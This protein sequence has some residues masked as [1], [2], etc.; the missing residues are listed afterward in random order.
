MHAWKQFQTIRNAHLFNYF[1][2]I[3]YSIIQFLWKSCCLDV[4]RRKFDKII[5][6]IIHFFAMIVN[7]LSHCRSDFF[8]IFLIEFQQFLHSID[9]V[10]N[11]F[12]FNSFTNWI[13]I[14]NI[15]TEAHS[16][17]KVFIHVKEKHWG[18]R[19]YV[20]VVIELR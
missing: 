15:R 4:F 13:I 14:R 16:W 20:V 8:H 6:L 7:L 3:K 12:C 11:F 9:D 18:E 1:E 17:M 2:W 5:D 10:I 19:E